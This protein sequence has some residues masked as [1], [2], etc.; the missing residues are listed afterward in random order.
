MLS[1]KG[2]LFDLDGVLVDSTPAVERVWRKWAEQRGLDP[3][4]VVNLAHGRRSI[5]TIRMVA[6]EL[7][8]EAANMEVENLEI[9]D[10]EGVV[11]LEGAC[12]LLRSLPADRWTVVTSGT[13]PLAT[14]RLRVAAMPVPERFVSANDVTEGKPSPEPYLKGAAL[15][16]FA[17]GDCVVIEDTAAG[18]RA[19]KAAGCRV[20]GL[21]TTYPAE[22]LAQADF[23]AGSCAELNVRFDGAMGTLRIEK[24]VRAKAPAS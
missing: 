11:A 15:L 21:T 17:P 5:E 19:G 23:I 13:R 14:T 18:I 9:G 12:D 6:P 16:G 20:I 3:D 1:C 24:I 7:E 22:E 4:H 8:A 10:T 2:I